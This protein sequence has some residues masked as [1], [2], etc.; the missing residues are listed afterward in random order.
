MMINK[1]IIFAIA[2]KNFCDNII[3]ISLY[4]L[5]C[6]SLSSIFFLFLVFSFFFLRLILLH[7]IELIPKLEKNL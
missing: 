4:L 2:Q 3:F 1:F 5:S 6:E 7:G